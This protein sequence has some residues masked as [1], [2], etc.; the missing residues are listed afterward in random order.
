MMRKRIIVNG[1]T[2]IWNGLFYEMPEEE[3][4]FFGC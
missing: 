1:M 4:K 3:R 2:V